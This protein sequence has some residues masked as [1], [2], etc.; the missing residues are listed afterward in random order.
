M[1]TTH[2]IEFFFHKIHHVTRGQTA[3]GFE[4]YL[5]FSVGLARPYGRRELLCSFFI[6]RVFAIHTTIDADRNEEP[7]KIFQKSCDTVSRKLC[8]ISFSKNISESVC[9]FT[10]K[11]VTCSRERERELLQSSQHRIT[12]IWLELSF[13]C[14]S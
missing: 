11:Y 6:L 5:I 3:P 1:K 9:H 14:R 12:F 4:N 2:T 13:I 10:P 7:I 8:G